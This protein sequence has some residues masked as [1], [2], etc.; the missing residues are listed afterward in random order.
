MRMT[1]AVGKH[2]IAEGLRRNEWRCPV[3][4]AAKEAF[5]TDRVMV[6]CD[7]ISLGPNGAGIRPGRYPMPADLYRF[8][9]DVD[10]GAVVGPGTFTLDVAADPFA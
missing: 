3:A 10:R 8:V 2:H 9:C 4:L 5:G 6:R 7:E 1:I